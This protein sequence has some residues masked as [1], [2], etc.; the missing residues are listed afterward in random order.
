MTRRT[1]QN[2]S[3]SAH[4]RLLNIARKT[5][6]PFN[7]VLQYFAMERFLYR[8]SQ[9]EHVDSF[10]L[11]GAL[12]FRIWGTPDSRPT[13]DIDFLAY[14]DNSPDNLAAIIRDVCAVDSVDDGLGF[15][16][17]TV[18]A[19]RIKE[20]ADY[21][22]VRIRFRGQLGNARIHMQVDVGFGDLIHPDAVQANYPV[23]LDLPAPS[24]RIYPP[25]T[26]VAE[27]AE[28]MVHLGSL[29]SRMKDFYDIWRMSQQ[30]NF[31]G[32]DL[33]AAI[34]RTFGRRETAVIEFDE[35]ITE[36]LDSETLA[37]QWTAFLSK[38][39]I[40]G[41]ETFTEVLSLIGKFLSPV[42]S[43]I[44]NDKALSQKWVPPGPWRNI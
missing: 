28:A 22:G 21:E 31:K 42:F 29:N 7:E 41:P 19:Q 5:A 9:T 25:E 27:K 20:D 24:L 16:P 23:L 13:R 34:S 1:L 3:A 14:L 43:S 12:L 35:L 33:C 6:R 39:S 40:S 18:D 32:T 4:Q 36:L 26:V 30:F 44:N 38:S 10:V 15:D 11:K 37:M 8:L 2:T 17:A